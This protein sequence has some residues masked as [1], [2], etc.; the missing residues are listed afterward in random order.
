L[1]RSKAELAMGVLD[2]DVASVGAELTAGVGLPKETLALVLGV[3]GVVTQD[4]T[5]ATPMTKAMLVETRHGY[6]SFKPF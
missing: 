3:Y 2:V 5:N 6:G 4:E 1:L